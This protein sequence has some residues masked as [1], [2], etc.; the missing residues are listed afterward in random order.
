MTTPAKIEPP[1]SRSN[2]NCFSNEDLL[3][4]ALELYSRSIVYPSEHMHNAAQTAIAE[5]KKRLSI[6][7]HAPQEPT[8]PVQKFETFSI[9]MALYAWQHSSWPWEAI[10]IT[11][12]DRLE[13]EIHQAEQEK[14]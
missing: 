3:Q 7:A 4:L 9:V 6:A 2:I 10:E 8:V 12:R 13:D 14:P 5:L 1:E 11:I